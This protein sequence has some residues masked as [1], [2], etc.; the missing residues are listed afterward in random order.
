M[1]CILVNNLPEGINN[2][3]LCCSNEEDESLERNADT[4]FI[5]IVLQYRI[6]SINILH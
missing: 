1:K 4:D 5:S 6:I 2:R 3:V